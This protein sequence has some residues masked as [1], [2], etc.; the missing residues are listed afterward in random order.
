MKI[1]TK[2]EVVIISDVH[3]NSFSS[4]KEEFLEIIK[5]LKTDLLILNGDIFDLHI[6]K[7]SFDLIKIIK[8]NKDIKEYVYI[9]GNHD[10]DIKKYYPDINIEEFVY[11]AN[12][13]IKV[14][15]GYQYDFIV[16]VPSK[17]GKYITKLRYWFEKTF[18]VNVK[19]F[20]E[21]Y[22][23]IIINWIY[24]KAQKKVIEENPDKVVIM[25]HTHIPKS[26]YPYY[27][28]GGFVDSVSSY[29]KVYIYEDDS[30]QIVLKE[31]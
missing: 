5:E 31:I 8:E 3:I 17:F 23:N 10:Y 26:E 12:H 2:K 1:Q 21:K 4:K 7:P 14:I 15:H 11:L 13:K 19:I 25:S 6:D 28:T 24:D 16:S 27:N 18:K 9:L 20:L 22:F 29:I 30:F